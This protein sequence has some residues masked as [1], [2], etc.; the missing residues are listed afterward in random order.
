MILNCQNFKNGLQLLERGQDDSLSFFE[1]IRLLLLLFLIA[2][3]NAGGGQ[4]RF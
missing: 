4:P 3:T 1:N 2:L